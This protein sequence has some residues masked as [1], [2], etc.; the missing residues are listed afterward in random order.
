MLTKNISEQ[1]ILNKF[2]SLLVLSCTCGIQNGILKFSFMMWLKES[3]MNI[4]YLGLFN[5]IFLPYS[6]KIIWMP[7]I[8]NSNLEKIFYNF[9]KKIGLKNLAN[10][11]KFAHR[12]ISIIFLQLFIILFTISFVFIN[13]M[14]VNIY[15]LIAYITI[16]AAFIFTN[17]SMVIAYQMETIKANNLGASEGKVNAAYQF[18]FWIGSVVLFG[19][20]SFISWNML[21]L[22]FAILFSFLLILIFFIEDSVS[23][24]KKSQTFK[25]KFL[26]PYHNLIKHNKDIIISLVLFICFY[27]MQDKLLASVTNYFFMDL[28]FKNQFLPGKTIG[29]GSM[30]L[31]GLFGSWLVKKLGYK[32]T[33]LLGLLGHGL[34]SSLFLVQ[35]MLF[36]KSHLLFYIIIIAEKFT[37]GFEATIFFTYQM[38]FCTKHFITQQFSI[39][40]AIDRLAGSLIS[41][42]SGYIIN[43]YGWNIFFI[44]SFFGALPA[45]FFLGNL[46]DKAKI[47]ENDENKLEQ[48]IETVE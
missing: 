26:E 11:T 23:N 38:I 27:R 5:L 3:G 39:F 28:G 8:E 22:Y 18:G 33:L 13:P 15:L 9:L 24:I 25:E 31:G 10:K 7:I 21:F 12:K 34:A 43:S 4:V 1:K 6:F 40:V 45:L 20:T 17:E 41:S 37:R 19:L 32:K 2:R 42:I 36:P 44:F 46:P 14:Q 35:S 16:Y 30:V 48:E 29:I 47:L